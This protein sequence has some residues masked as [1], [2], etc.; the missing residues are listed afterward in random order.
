MDQKAGAPAVTVER[1]SGRT[2]RPLD[3]E[4]LLKR[5]IGLL[6][7]TAVIALVPAA[8]T[9]AYVDSTSTVSGVHTTNGQFGSPVNTFDIQMDSNPGFGDSVPNGSVQ[10]SGTDAHGVV[11]SW[12]AFGVCMHVDSVGQNATIL[13]LLFERTNE[14]DALD[15]VLIHV[16][17][18]EAAGS[19][20]GTGDRMD[21]TNLNTNQYNR[22][23][24][25]GCADTPA[26]KRAISA[27]DITIT[28]GA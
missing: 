3:Q 2:G 22:Q 10:F 19:E 15:A 9:S 25:N 14:P 28:K 1:S 4:G 11:H 13:A 7:A 21:V 26:G 5:I 17:D 16:T 27:G 12:R 6:S 20:N 23:Y 18:T 24:N 8:G